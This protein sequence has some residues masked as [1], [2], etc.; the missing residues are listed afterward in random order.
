VFLTAPIELAEDVGNQEVV[1]MN[2]TPGSTPI[3]IEKMTKERRPFSRN[4][5]RSNTT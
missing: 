5:R 2:A 1:P 3:T 4:R